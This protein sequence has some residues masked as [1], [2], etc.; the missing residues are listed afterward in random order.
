MNLENY[1]KSERYGQRAHQLEWEAMNDPFLQDAID[2]YDLEND[3]QVY[4]LKKLREQ[5]KKR[6]K[7]NLH[8]LQLWNIAAGALI[9][10]C[11]TFFS[12]LLNSDKKIK[13]RE[14]TAYIDNK[15]NDPAIINI[16][17]N[18]T[19]TDDDLHIF[20]DF[21]A[22][23]DNTTPVLDNTDVVNVI[24]LPKS[25][26]VSW[27]KP[28]VKKKPPVQ[29][30]E[31][32]E[33]DQVSS[34]NQ[35]QIYFRDQILSNQAV[36][37]IPPAYNNDDEAKGTDYFSQTPKPTVGDKAY[38]DYLKKNRSSLAGN[39][40][41]ILIFNVNEKGRP[42]DIKVQR[43]LSQAADR[44]AVRLLQEGPNWT[45]GNRSAHLVIDF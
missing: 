8:Y 6:T 43:S 10:I 38:T 33:E 1:I 5:I 13:F 12:F 18:S 32:I 28:K 17:D 2:R 27:S 24:R 20:D 16:V 11:L 26:P 3:H 45:V 35:Q 36:Q 19:D 9:I 41:V 23:E 7:K 22:V 34:W 25:K 39:G 4:P 40:I 44:E 21:A 42:V 31:T 37:E 15:P 14:N 30:E 29:Q